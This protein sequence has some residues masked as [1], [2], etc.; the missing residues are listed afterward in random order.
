MTS[1][2]IRNAWTNFHPD[3]KKTEES[4]FANEEK[5]TFLTFINQQQISCPNDVNSNNEPTK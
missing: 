3:K 2:D 1:F 5:V 4:R